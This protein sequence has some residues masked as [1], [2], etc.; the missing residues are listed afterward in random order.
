VVLIGGLK[1]VHATFQLIPL[2]SKV[3]SERCLT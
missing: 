2:M 1:I 3:S